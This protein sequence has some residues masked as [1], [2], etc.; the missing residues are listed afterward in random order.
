MCDQDEHQGRSNISSIT[1]HPDFCVEKRYGFQKMLSSSRYWIHTHTHPR[2]M[3]THRQQRCW[4]L[5]PGLVHAKHVRQV[6]YLWAI[7]QPGLRVDTLTSD[8]GGL[9]LTTSAP[10]ALPAKGL[11][12]LHLWMT[13]PHLPTVASTE[14]SPYLD[15]FKPCAFLSSLLDY[16]LTAVLILLIALMPGIADNYQR[17]S[18]TQVLFLEGR[19]FISASSV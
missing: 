4:G 3:F 5:N 14:H 17:F 11:C 8:P 6:F 12:A 10:C 9:V 13:H 18:K 16:K 19:F 15:D 7:P 1:I 2:C